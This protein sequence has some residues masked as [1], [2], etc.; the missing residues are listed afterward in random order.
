MK[1]IAIITGGVVTNVAV[2]DGVAA[3]T[4]EGVLVDVTGTPEVGKGWTYVDGVFKPPAQ[5]DQ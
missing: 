4:P 1:R 2:W 3:W 5:V